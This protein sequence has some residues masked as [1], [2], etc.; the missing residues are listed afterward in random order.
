LRFFILKL[1]D[2]QFAGFEVAF[3]LILLMS[4]P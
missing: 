2:H 4:S 3:Q 1:I